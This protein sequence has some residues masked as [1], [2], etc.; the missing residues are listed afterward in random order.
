M[1]ETTTRSPARATPAR[2]PAK[3]AGKP[4]GFKT[5]GLTRK[6]WAIAIVV[7][8]A[9]GLAYYLY[10]RNQ[11]AAAQATAPTGQGTTDTSPADNGLAGSGVDTSGSGG[12][13]A[14]APLGQ[15]D[16]DLLFNAQQGLL[17]SQ[18]DLVAELAGGAQTLAQ[19]SEQQ[20]GS[21]AA[22][23][24][25]LPFGT[26]TPN[27]SP[28]AP[29]TPKTATPAT[30]AT[31]HTEPNPGLQSVTS[32]PGSTLGKAPAYTVPTPTGA[33][34]K[35]TGGPISPTTGLTGHGPQL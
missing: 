3:G 27:T 12:G 11:A 26:S 34:K 9:A 18:E 19:T 29:A 20:L 25:A 10:R 17:Q 4:A 24:L 13:G 32:Q 8:A 6:Q 33:T 28:S 35:V 5:L 21:L 23:A 16:Y 15:S 2:S 31:P 1:A 30:T 7:V 22:A 14:A